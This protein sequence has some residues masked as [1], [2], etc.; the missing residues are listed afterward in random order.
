MIPLDVRRD[1]RRYPGIIDDKLSVLNRIHGAPSAQDYYAS[2]FWFYLADSNDGTIWVSNTIMPNNPW[3]V[4]DLGVPRTV[5]KV[6][7]YQ[8][9]G[10][11]RATQFKVEVAQD[12]VNWYLVH[13]TAGGLAGGEYIFYVPL[14]RYRYWKATALAGGNYGWN[15]ASFE[16]FGAVI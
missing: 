11:D 13:T 1:R 6:R 8:S 16:L 14:L 10:V 12:L 5:C 9:A 4:L 7:I 3:C 15:V 2:Y